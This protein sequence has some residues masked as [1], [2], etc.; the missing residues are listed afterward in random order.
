MRTRISLPLMLKCAV[1]LLFCM[2]LL[3]SLRHRPGSK[4]DPFQAGQIKPGMTLEQVVSILDD[5]PGNYSTLTEAELDYSYPVAG[6]L[7][8]ATDD[9]LICITTWNNGKVKEVR[10]VQSWARFVRK[11]TERPFWQRVKDWLGI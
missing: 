2:A 4:I 9:Y 6:E 10:C 1:V 11:F 3:W 8:W 5:P 7:R